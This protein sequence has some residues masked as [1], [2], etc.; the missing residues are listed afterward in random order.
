M[1]AIQSSVE[2]QSGHRVVISAETPS[3]LRSSL[4][5]AGNGHRR[6]DTQLKV[7]LCAGLLQAQ[8]SSLDAWIDESGCQK[9]RAS[10]LR[11]V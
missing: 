8:S 1:A 3:G 5:K 6:F 7:R 4:E 11:L 9:R 2:E 10:P